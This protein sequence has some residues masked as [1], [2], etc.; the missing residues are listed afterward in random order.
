[1]INWYKQKALFLLTVCSLWN[2]GSSNAFA[3]S[4]GKAKECREIDN[5]YQ[6]VYSFET[7]DSYINVCQLDDKFYYHRQSKLDSS[8]DLVLPAEAIFRGSVFQAT[9]GKITYF[10]GI[11]SDRYYS[12]VMLNDNEIVLEPEVEPPLASEQVAKVDVKTVSAEYSSNQPDRN[13]ISSASLG[14]DS[15]ARKCRFSTNLY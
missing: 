9:V 4:L 11:D 7:E 13:S 1:M 10:A 5:A 8:N 2:Y 3:N 15:T 12:S 14:L 6:E